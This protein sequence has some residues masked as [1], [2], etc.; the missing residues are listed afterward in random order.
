M[1]SKRK[2]GLK[3]RAQKMLHIINYQRNANQSHSEVNATSYPLGWVQTTRQISF[4]KDME[5]LEASHTT[6]G[7]L[8]GTATLEKMLTVP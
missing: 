4:G 1:S 2:G 6:G 5:K 3:E 7:N 8:N